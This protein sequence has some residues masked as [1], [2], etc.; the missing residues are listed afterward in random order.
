MG[1]E[2]AKPISCC[3]AFIFLLSIILFAVS[4]D[5]LQPYEV[6]IKFNGYA[7]KIDED[8]VYNNGRYFLGVGSWFVKYPANLVAADFA[9]ANNLRAWSKEGQLIHIDLGF[10]YRLDRDKIVDIYKKYDDGYHTRMIQIAIRSIK[11]VT[12]MYEASAF[13]EDR[14]LIGNHMARELRIRMA[15]EDMIMELFA[16]RAI[17]IP[18][19]FEKKVVDK[20]VELQKK[21]TAYHKKETAGKRADI[22]VKRGQ[23]RAVVNEK[24]AVA[25]ADVIKTVNAAKA[26]GFE[27]LAEQQASSYAILKSS[28]GMDTEELLKFRF[29]QLFNRIDAPSV[30]VGLGFETGMLNVASG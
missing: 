25:N 13:F 28:L 14:T 20:V 16:L 15:E 26:K 21:K 18:D 7:L 2:E 30:S 5:K 3:C 10:Y 12:I 27:M 9:G 1:G 11:Q 29:A 8:T 23:G 6:G 4:F 17:D 19:M 24:L 22:D